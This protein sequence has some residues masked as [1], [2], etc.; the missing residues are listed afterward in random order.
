MTLDERIE[1]LT[2]SVELLSLMH[3]D[4][5]KRFTAWMEAQE[6]RMKDNEALL[7]NHVQQ[8]SILTAISSRVI[9]LSDRL[10]NIANDH[11]HR[12]NKL[13]GQ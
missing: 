11:E 8:L 5:E 10:V 2:Q 13:E 7:A 12:I 4:N 6:A 3:Q 1:A 9:E